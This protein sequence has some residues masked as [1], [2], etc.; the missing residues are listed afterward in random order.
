LFS[1][2]TRLHDGRVKTW[3]KGAGVA[4]LYVLAAVVLIWALSVLVN[5]L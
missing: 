2:S 4:L 3:V 1:P 5:H